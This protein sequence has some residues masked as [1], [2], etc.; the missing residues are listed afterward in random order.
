MRCFYDMNLRPGQWNVPLVQ[1]LCE[2][3]SVLKLN[4]VEARLLGELKGSRPP[5]SLESF[6]KVGQSKYKFD[7]ICVTLGEEGCCVYEN[8][9]PS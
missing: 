4:E 8:Q 3:A 5:F 6:C 1:R 7:A 9:S 2:L